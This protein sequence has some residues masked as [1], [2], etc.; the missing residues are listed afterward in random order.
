MKYLCQQCAT[1]HAPVIERLTGY[2]HKASHCDECKRIT[3]TA[4]VAASVATEV[5][6]LDNDD[7]D[8]RLFAQWSAS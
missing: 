7:L 8:E 6:V 2:I 3:K 4:H 1:K 5:A